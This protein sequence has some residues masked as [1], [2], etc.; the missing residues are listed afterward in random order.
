MDASKYTNKIKKLNKKY[1]TVIDE[2][3]SLL[4]D[5]K[6]DFKAGKLT[7]AYYNNQT[8]D[9]N[10]R[11]VQLKADTQ[12][13]IRKLQKEFHEDL[14]DWLTPTPEKIDN[15]DLKLLGGPLTLSE[16][17]VE[18]LSK[19]HKNDPIMQ[20][21]LKEYADKKGYYVPSSDIGEDRK[22]AFDDVVNVAL[23]GIDNPMG[24]WGFTIKDERHFDTYIALCDRIVVVKKI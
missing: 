15:E 5:L 21:A 17:E 11:K 24:Y 6:A 22:T 14:K 8:N 7:T 9:L 23:T 16:K 13:E 18:N 4:E 12:Q 19:K 2:L 1:F 10:Q 20:R 3:D